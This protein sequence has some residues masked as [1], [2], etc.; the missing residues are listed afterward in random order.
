MDVDGWPVPPQYGDSVAT[1]LKN[2]PNLAKSSKVR[3]NNVFGRI[4]MDV[5]GCM[6]MRV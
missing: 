2:A 6:W 3:Q 1:S 4:C 5:D